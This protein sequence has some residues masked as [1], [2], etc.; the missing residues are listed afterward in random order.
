MGSI[1]IEENVV[2]AAG[3]PHRFTANSIQECIKEAG[4]LPQLRT[5]LYEKRSIPEMKEQLIDY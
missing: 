5:Q 1:M 3:A 2:S 4:F